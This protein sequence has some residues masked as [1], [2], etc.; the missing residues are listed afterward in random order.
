[1]CHLAALG[2]LSLTACSRVLVEKPILAKEVEIFR[3]FDGCCW[4]INVFVRYYHRL[5]F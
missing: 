4:F 1:M 3:T 2:I 5:I